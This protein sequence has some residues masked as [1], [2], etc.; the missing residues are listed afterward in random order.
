[1]VVKTFRQDEG[2]RGLTSRSG[3]DTDGVN[4]KHCFIIQNKA[5]PEEE[6]SVSD[7]AG[8]CGRPLGRILEHGGSIR[9]DANY[10][11]GHHSLAEPMETPKEESP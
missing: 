2:I 11:M 6:F 9:L 10:R 4:L 8:I 5:H 7:S 1:M 3:W